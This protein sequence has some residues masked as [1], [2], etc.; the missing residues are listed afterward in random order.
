MQRFIHDTN[1]LKKIN[2]TITFGILFFKTAWFMLY[3]PLNANLSVWG[4]K[5]LANNQ[6]EKH[7]KKCYRQSCDYKM[8]FIATNIQ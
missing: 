2:V 1:K 5:C 3:V 4:L 8:Q 7:T 6:K